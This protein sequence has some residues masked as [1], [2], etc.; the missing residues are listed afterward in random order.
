MEGNCCLACNHSVKISPLTELINCKKYNYRVSPN[1]LA[2][3]NFELEKETD[4]I[5]VTWQEAFEAGLEGKRIKVYGQYLT[6]PKFET[7]HF[8]LVYLSY[9]PNY[10]QDLLKK[11]WYIEKS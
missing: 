3:K 4:E 10:Y 6:Y 7:L 11:E 1:S 2:C 9:R 8:A 5:G